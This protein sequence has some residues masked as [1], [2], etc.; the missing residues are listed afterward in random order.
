MTKTVEENVEL[1]GKITTPT[2]NSNLAKRNVADLQGVVQLLKEKKMLVRVKSPVDIKHEMAGIATR[3]DGGKAVLFEKLK[4]TDVSLLTGL[5]WNREVLAEIFNVK[6]KDLPFLTA[7]SIEKWSKNPIEPI[8]VENGPA[9]EVI[10]KN[11]ENLLKDIP[12]PTHGL[13]DGGPYLDS[14]VLIAKDPETE[15]GTHPYN[16]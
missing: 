8:V 11:K 3:F 1:A 12:I 5:Y 15:Y 4:N 14:C 7:D 10:I 6:E 16:V 9:N 13:Q 2:Y